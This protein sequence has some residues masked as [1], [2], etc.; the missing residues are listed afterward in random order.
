MFV[1]NLLLS[2]F[3]GTHLGQILELH[4]SGPVPNVQPMECEVDCPI[5]LF[6]LFHV[7][8]YW[9]QNY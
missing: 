2:H 6:K 7:L 9:T 4:V 1:I 5:L 3:V 8:N